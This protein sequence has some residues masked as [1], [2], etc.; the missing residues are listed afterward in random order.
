MPAIRN[1]APES[2]II[3]SSLIGFIPELRTIKDPPALRIPQIEMIL[4]I[5]LSRKIITLSCLLKPNSNNEFASWLDLLFS[6][7]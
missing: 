6:C 5:E 3:Y 4:S 7:S 2:F 1:F